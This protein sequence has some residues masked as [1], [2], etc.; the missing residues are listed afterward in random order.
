LELTALRRP[1]L[2]FPLEG[3]FEQQFHVANRLERHQAGIK[4]QYRETT[5]AH[6][7]ATVLANIGKPVN[8]PMIATDGARQAA[9]LLA[10]LL[11]AHRR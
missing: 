7:A 3:H 1:F 10:G 5:A 4:L 11:Q 2:Y 9:K 6:L 8:Y